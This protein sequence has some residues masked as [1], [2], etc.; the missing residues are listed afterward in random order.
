MV[1]VGAVTGLRW[2]EVAGLRVGRVDLLRRT[3]SVAEQVTRGTGGRPV[4][5]APKSSA[6]RRELTVP[7][8]LAEVLSAHLISRGITGAD[9]DA[10]VFAATEGRPLDYANWRRRVWLPAVDAAGLQGLGFHDLRRANATAMVRAKVDVKTA[11]VRLGHT[12]PG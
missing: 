9:S 3:I 5:T 10:F 4:V 7:A 2:G 8:A 12:D 6:G 1:W 11:Q